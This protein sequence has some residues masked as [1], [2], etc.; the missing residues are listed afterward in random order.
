MQARSPLYVLYPAAV[1][2]TDGSTVVIAK[3]NPTLLGTYAIRVTYFPQL[4]SPAASQGLGGAISYEGAFCYGP[5]SAPGYVGVG[6]TVVASNLLGAIGA[7]AM[8]F[9]GIDGLY[10]QLSVTGVVGKNIT[11]G[12]AI[13][14][15]GPAY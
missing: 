1:Q 14:V 12:C 15:F 3:L 8:S 4:N 11:H 2:T 7:P 6:F 5:A 13:E 10:L 9:A